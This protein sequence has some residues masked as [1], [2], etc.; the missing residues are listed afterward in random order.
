M[1]MKKEPLYFV[2]S[3]WLLQGCSGFGPSPTS[4]SIAMPSPASEPGSPNLANLLQGGA[5]SNEELQLREVLRRPT[6]LKFPVKVGVLLFY[7]RSALA[8]DDQKTLLEKS[9]T[10]L[11]QSGLVSDLILI[12]A[13]L[14]QTNTNIET[15]RQIG[16]RFQVDVLLLTTGS[17]E[18]R[19]AAQQPLSFADQFTDKAYWES[20]TKLEVL[21]L[22]IY[23]GTF[24]RPFT[25]ATRNGP[26]VLDRA[27]ISYSSMVYDLKK[28]AEQGAW[29]QL[30]TE[31]LAALQKIKER[32]P[33]P[34]PTP[35]PT[36]S[37]GQP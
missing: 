18:F 13:S 31:F 27:D 30:Q 34:S 15:L 11:K 24:L 4:A 32:P 16:S 37:G 12:P 6:Q 14:I 9:A 36:P 28:Q 2:I 33:V 26:Q 1:Q 17:T 19:K 5:I 23:S 7:Y 35:T 3:L 20:L 21:A 8:N 10:E 25:L 29:Q 22:D